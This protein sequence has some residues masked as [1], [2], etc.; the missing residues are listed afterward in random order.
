MK[1][2]PHRPATWP[3]SLRIPLVVA[4]LMVVIVFAVMTMRVAMIM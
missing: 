4:L 1:R 2:A 3:I